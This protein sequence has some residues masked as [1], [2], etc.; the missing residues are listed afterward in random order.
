VNGSLRRILTHDNVAKQSILS[1]TNID[2]LCLL[3]PL[4][5]AQTYANEVKFVWELH[6][7]W[8]SIRLSRKLQREK[9]LELVRNIKIDIKQRLFYSGI[10]AFSKIPTQHTLS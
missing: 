4:T 7:Y 10:R 1:I 3:R 5:T 9:A 2:K 6:R 8:M